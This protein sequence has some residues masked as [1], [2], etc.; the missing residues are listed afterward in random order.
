VP[1]ANVAQTL[2]RADEKQKIDLLVALLLVRGAGPGP[3]EVGRRAGGS[4]VQAAGGAGPWA[5][6]CRRAGPP[7]CGWPAPLVWC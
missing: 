1:T 7:V 6:A 2:E 4:V 3:G 5:V